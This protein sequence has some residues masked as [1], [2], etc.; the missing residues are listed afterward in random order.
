[1]V[2]V[3]SDIH[4]QYKKF[5]T[6]LDVIQFNYSDTLYIIGDIID[7]GPENLKMI[8]K[9]MKTPNIKMIIGNHEDMML[10][11]FKNKST[12]DYILWYQNGGGK[13]DAEFS[14]LSEKEQFRILSF[15]DNLPIEKEINVNG[16]KFLL[17]HGCYVPDVVKPMYKPGAYRNAVVWNRLN[18]NDIG[19]KDKI[20]VLG[21]TPVYHFSDETPYRIFYHGNVIN[22]DCGMARYSLGDENSRL[23]CLCL[24]NMREYYV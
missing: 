24:D 9:V 5:M 10:N 2:F 19:P 17:V 15:F 21:H 11:F 7:R 12:Y 23:A 20:V 22:I 16:Q 14:Q 1:M 8:E 4:G 13:T 3:M 6:M 18:S